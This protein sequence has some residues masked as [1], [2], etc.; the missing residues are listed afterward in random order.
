M[1]I[2]CYSQ[3]ILN[4]F[5]GVMNIISTGKADA[6]TTDGVN[7]TLY[8]YDN[9]HDPDQEPEE[10]AQIDMPELRYGEWNL[11]RGLRR[12]PALP[13]YH[14]DEI[15]RIGEDLVQ[16]LYLYAD[17]IPFAFRDDYELWLLDADNRQPLALLDSVCRERDIYRPD[18]L[19]WKAGNRCRQY[20]NSTLVQLDDDD[21]SHADL[22]DR[23]VNAR[24][25]E[26]P[27]AQ[28]FLR[29]HSGYGL[30]L[31]GA[32][33]DAALRG[34][35]LSPRLF[36]RMFVE[37]HWHNEAAATLVDEFIDWLSPWLLLMD[38]LKDSQ[39]AAFEAVA[40]QQAMLVDEMHH[41]YP[42]IVN[43]S[44]INAA[45]VE[46]A[47]RKAAPEPRQQDEPMHC[48]YLEL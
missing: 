7:W 48:C 24:A 9:F 13:S 1:D 16:A 8:I 22:L 19:S 20:F 4:P 32:N 38:F 2:S 44:D 21:A 31:D 14:Y 41:L 30:G 11:K 17:H 33:L 5:R 43:P 39:R 35:E 37:Q 47:L 42:K 10:F 18:N 40:R 25:G 23:L 46:A 12:A 26:T 28:W 36:P 15:Q 45:R 27:S 34:R 6:V 29:K 3:R